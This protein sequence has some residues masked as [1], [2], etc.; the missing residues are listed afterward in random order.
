MLVLF[1]ATLFKHQHAELFQISQRLKIVSIIRTCAHVIQANEYNQCSVV[2]S[3]VHSQLLSIYVDGD[4]ELVVPVLSAIL[5]HPPQSQMAV[6]Q[7][8]LKEGTLGG[9]ILCSTALSLL[10]PTKFPLYADLPG[11]H[12][13]EFPP[14]TLPTDL[15]TSTARPDITLVSEE[16]VT[17]LELTIPSNSKE[18]IVKAK[19]ERPTSLTIVTTIC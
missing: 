2:I 8:S 10:S 14:A 1:R 11:L 12:S 7:L 13:S 17:M 6:K 16:S 18:A 19:R 9:T 4:T 15:S 3:S 5:L